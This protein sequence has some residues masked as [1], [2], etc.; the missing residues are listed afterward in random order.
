[1]HMHAASELWVQNTSKLTTSDKQHIRLRVSMHALVGAIEAQREANL[2]AE[3]EHRLD[4]NE[5]AFDTNIELEGAAQALSGV[6]A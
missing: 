5:I 2:A 6:G 1:M 4:E 3:V